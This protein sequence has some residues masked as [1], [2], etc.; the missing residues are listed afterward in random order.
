MVG[1]K[2]LE[3][4]MFRLEAVRETFGSQWGQWP[5]KPV[6]TG[7]DMGRHV[8]LSVEAHGPQGLLARQAFQNLHGYYLPFTYALASRKAH[9]DDVEDII[10]ETW[11][12]V[13]RRL[14]EPEPIE[15][16]LS[17]LEAICR[18]KVADA[19]ERRFRR[20][21]LIRDPDHS[22]PWILSLDDPMDS[23]APEGG[24]WGESL[25]SA[26][27]CPETAVLQR[28]RLDELW[29]LLDRL[30]EIWRLAVVYRF[31]NQ[32]SVLETARTM[33]TSED[34]IKKYVFRAVRRLREWMQGDMEFWLA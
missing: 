2:G 26:E 24:R 28:E 7:V 32:M 18:N 8:Q 11:V 3:S 19:N 13:W 34:A 12:A 17:L 33:N 6:N 22:G 4:G 23:D 10:Q 15:R 20:K 1:Q 25:E 29:K 21:R 27:P 9:A 14:L 31:F 16:F 5:V 30:P